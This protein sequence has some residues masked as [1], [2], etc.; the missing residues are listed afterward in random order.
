MFK[1][2]LTDGNIQP[3]FTFCCKIADTKCILCLKLSLLQ[4][5][6]ACAVITKHLYVVKIS[7][8]LLTA[9][10]ICS[11]KVQLIAKDIDIKAAISVEIIVTGAIITLV[12]VYV[13]LLVFTLIA[14][15]S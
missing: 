1:I 9:Q 11:S 15:T 5:S 7:L 6:Y 4:L 13:D 10:D 14:G 2:I 12:N 8:T 3:V